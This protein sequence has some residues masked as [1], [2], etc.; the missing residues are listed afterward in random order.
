MRI[1]SSFFFVALLLAALVLASIGRPAHAQNTATWA[2]ASSSFKSN[3]PK[4]FSFTVEATSSAGKIV[5]AQV[6]WRHAPAASR[7]RL[8]GAVNETGTGA[9]ADWIPGPSNGVPQ[10]VG[11][12]YWWSLVDEAG[13][14][15]ESEHQFADY[16]DDSRVWHQAESEDIKVFWEDGVP[17][18][19]GQM[20]LDA[21]L[22]AR[23]VYEK[24]WE[25]PL[26]YVSRAILFNNYETWNEW[27]PGAG[28][29]ASSGGS[30]TVVAGRTSD[31]W[32]ATVQIFNPFKR[33]DLETEM[34]ELTY[35][36]LV[37]EVAH[38]YQFANGGTRGDFWF[39]EGNATFHELVGLDFILNRVRNLAASGTLPSLQGGGPSAR[40][41]F[42]RDAYDVGGAFFIW[43]EETYGPDAHK[44]LWSMIG[45]GRPWKNAL[46]MI[47]QMNFVD[48]ETAF[49]TWL[50]AIDPVA[51]TPLPD[52]PLVFPP[53]PTYEPTPKK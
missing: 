22:A 50:G 28:V 41:A 2:V 34:K 7:L 17:D 27:S 25:K 44:L 20:A 26:G 6:L 53:T 39:F 48:M 23:P 18:A 12:E 45:S 36:T 51:P 30:S 29:V 13:N 16:T 43:L 3:Y 19:I 10:W 31:S 52:I 32:G 33:D 49:R 21:M 15:F 42:A 46:E 47:T 8:S 11:V 37:H 35:S 5:A 24:N 4:G 9:T 40:G 38:L 14:A 1:R